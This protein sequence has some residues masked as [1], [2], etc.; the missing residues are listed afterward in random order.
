MLGL[1]VIAVGGLKESWLTA[2]RDEY[3][4][5]LAAFCAPRIIEIDEHRLGRKPSAAE[6]ENGLLRE[7]KAILAQIAKLPRQTLAIALRIEGEE[8]GSVGLAERIRKL[9][10]E[11]PHVAFVIGGSHGLSPEVARGCGMSLSM[12]RMTFPHQLARI[13]LLEQLYRAFSINS[14][15][16]YHK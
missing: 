12:S 6:I 2:A 10:L 3:L 14:G 7:G 4:K 8:L 11:R 9:S 5:R 16:E 15:M 1:T 13:M